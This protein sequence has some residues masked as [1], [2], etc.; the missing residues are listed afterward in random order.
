MSTGWDEI[1]WAR[2]EGAYGPATETPVILRDIAS[3]DPQVAADGRFEFWSSLQHQ[4]SV[5]PATVVAAPFLVE[6][7]ARPETHGRA[8]LLT[9]LGQLCDPA[10]SPDEVRPEVRA[11]VSAVSER[12]LPCLGDPDPAVREGAAFA[13]AHSGP[14]HAAALR[15]RHAVESVPAVRASLL[16]AMTRYEEAPS[17]GPLTEPFP[18]PAAGAYVLARAGLPL[19]PAA[20]AAYERGE[21]WRG[22]WSDEVRGCPADVTRLLDNEGTGALVDMLAESLFKAARVGAAEGLRHRFELLRS[23]PVELMSRLAPLLEDPDPEVRAAA[24]GAARAAGRPVAALAGRLTEIALDGDETALEILVRL[25]SPGWK[26]PALA[27]WAEGRDPSAA[28]LFASHPPAFDAEVLSVVRTRLAAGDRATDLVQLLRRWGPAAG[29]AVPDIVAAYPRAR[30]VAADALVAIGSAALPA[31]PALRE[32]AADG[33]IRAG[34]AVWRLTGDAEALV[35]AVLAHDARCEHVCPWDLRYVSAAGT[36]VA[37]LVPHLRARLTGSSAGSDFVGAATAG[38]AVDDSASSLTDEDRIA[39]AE[40]LWRATGDPEEALPTVTAVLDGKFDNYAARLAAAIPDPRLIPGLQ[41]LFT[42][43]GRSS[44]GWGR[45][46]AARAL[47]Q[48]GTPADDLAPALLAMVQDSGRHDAVDLIVEL[49]AVSAV[50]TLQ[51]LAERDER[52]IRHGFMDYVWQ[53]DA[54]RDHLREAVTRLTS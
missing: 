17:P 50:P 6:L 24:V 39:I 9:T 15:A 31:V 2:F 22:P 42:G 10:R 49:G 23:A 7:A 3:A 51:D 18:V 26:Q 12:L 27:I 40:V 29:D 20:A 43:D 34:H 13:L 8:D 44:P 32:L 4:G 16:L 46:D 54:L 36:A 52:V 48:L 19:S 53:D 45:L 38:S 14:Q 37:A 47:W 21:V 1:E 5:Y 41:R 35:G 33:D 30:G 25:G 11:A 28:T